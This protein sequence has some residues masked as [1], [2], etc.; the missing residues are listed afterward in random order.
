MPLFPTTQWPVVAAV[1]SGDAYEKQRALDTLLAVYWRPVY[2]YLRTRWKRGKEDASDLAQ[3]F[4]VELLERSLIEKFEGEKG[5][6]RTY[7]RLCIDGFVSN[8]MR[9]LHR[10]KRGGGMTFLSVHTEVC[11][12]EVER[13]LASQTLNP[14]DA[15][16]REWARSVFG[17][18]LERLK[19]DFTARG[20]SIHL[21][22]FEICELGT[23]S[24]ER[25]SYA[26]L[27]ARFG[28]RTSDVTNWLSL[29]RREFR[30]HVTSVLREM[31]GS[32]RE[33]RQ[34]LRSLSG[35]D[36]LES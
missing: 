23:S 33:F 32:E 4:F 5:R 9:A 25:P 1:R 17:V 30:M 26:E 22:L 35:R 18:A 28:V 31:T 11:Q 13:R 24:G 36:T 19:T 29:A 3:G 8:E 15:F 20:R 2:L 16:E 27:A 21:S 12:E 10:V 34:E 7:L 14:E 6:F